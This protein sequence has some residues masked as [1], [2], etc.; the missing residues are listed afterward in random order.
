MTNYYDP[1]DA[2]YS[3]QKNSNNTDP[4]VLFDTALKY[5]YGRGVSQDYAEAFRCFELAAYWGHAGAQN[6]L[7]RAFLT[8]NIVARNYSEA[9]KWFKLAADQGM[10]EAQYSLGAMYENG[11]GVSQ[12]GSLAL[13]WYELSA[14]QGF[15]LAQEAVDSLT[16]LSQEEVDNLI[17]SV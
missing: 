16:E 6:S 14:A 10:P 13:G 9:L 12:N 8:G 4:S 7:G 3:R 5:Y 15:P 11:I 2:Q 17:E 1:K